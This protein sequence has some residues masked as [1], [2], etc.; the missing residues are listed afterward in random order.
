MKKSELYSLVREVVKQ[1]TEVREQSAD[2]TVNGNTITIENLEL[3]DGRLIGADAEG[4]F[5]LENSGIGSYEYW[6]TKLKDEGEDSYSLEG[7]EI[8]R[9]WFQDENGRAVSNINIKDPANKEIL[10]AIEI[11]LENNQ[12]AIETYYNENPPEADYPEYERDDI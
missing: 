11:V 7:W 1:F 5:T 2:W 3:E 6:G 9:A 12:D 4:T 8:I 10:T